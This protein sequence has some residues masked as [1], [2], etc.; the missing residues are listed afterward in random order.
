[1]RN[2]ANVQ[3]EAHMRD[4]S[5]Q[6]IVLVNEMKGRVKF[7]GETKFAKGIWYGIE[8]DKP[9]G[10]NDGSV[11]G[12]RYFDID[13][14][15]ANLNGG[16]YGLFCR[17]DTLRFYKPTGDEHSSPNGN[18]AQETIKKLQVECES[19]T[20]ELNRRKIENHELKIAAENL[21]ISETDLLSKT[22]DLDKL[23]K[24]L[25]MENGNMKIH[26]ENF[27]KM[28]DVPNDAMARDLDK[29]TL[30]ERNCL[31]QG[32]LEQ[33]KL[34]YDKAMKMQEDLLEE[35]TQLLEENA[36]LSKKVSDLGLQLQQTN[37]T[38]G[39]LVL[40]IEAQSKSSNIVDRLTND[41]IL[42]T[43]NIKALNSELEE[44]HV[45]EELE[46]NLRITYEQLEQELRLQLSN[47][48]SALENKKEL[49]DTY[50]EENERLK[51]TLE[52]FEEKATHKS[53]S[54]EL[55]VN[56]LQEELYQNKL[57]K[58]FYQIYEPFTQSHLQ[59]LS[60]QLQYLAEVIESENFGNLENIQIYTILKVLSS[61]SYTLHIHSMEN[62]SDH[63]EETLQCFKV[64][65]A[66]ISMWL[67][68][69]LQRKFSS[70]QETAFSICHFLDENKYLD[71]DV[72]LILK[73]LYPIF[74]TTVPKL[75]AFF[76]AS[77]NLG[78]D[79]TL[80][81][82]GSLY[83]MSFS[84]AARIDKFIVNKQ[85]SIPDNS[86]LLTPSCNINSSSI[87]MTF[88]SGPL[89]FPQ[90]Y[91]RICSLKKLK[92]FFEGVEVL[93]ENIII[94]TEQPKQPSI[95]SASESNN[96]DS[97][98]LNSLV[99]DHLNE[100]NIRLKEVLLQKENVL[101]ELET[102][103]KIFMGRDSE[104][105]TLEQ[106][107]K[108]LQVEL[109]NKIEENCGKSEMLNK[110][111]EENANLLNRLKNMELSLYQIK[112]NSK[113]NKIYLDREKVDRVNLVSEIMELKETIKRRIKEHKQV[114]IDFSWLDE[115]PTME[116]KQSSK[117]HLYRSLN[118]LEIEM[119]NFMS[120][121]RIL[122]MK[123]DR[124]LTEDELWHENDRSY[125][126][127]L[128][129]KRKNIRIK[130]QNTFTYNK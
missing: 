120:T 83:E 52:S 48:Q 109:N 113:L 4:I 84:F 26:L 16:Y 24:K 72:T 112:D 25:K 9:L 12:T 88:F 107:V 115:F 70:K 98:F 118:T 63:L 8:L 79:D 44:L 20:F 56:T 64:N 54:L 92:A 111:K 39:D 96:K 67:S 51:A 61:I 103:I 85:V 34:S 36:V 66:P 91:K 125:I 10:K 101:T 90:E 13:V 3:V 38:I 23:V 116:N 75:L 80:C 89:F 71:K 11:S 117:G 29:D 114:R 124:S 6:D 19:L 97:N 7:I 22:S 121:S 37:N 129:R 104:R 46:E 55:K 110:L 40:Q 95:S 126:A 2:N 30:Q 60:S 108:T 82:I 102:K 74:E 45:K 130:S 33:T 78:D 122:D 28:L 41:N 119:V 68:E 5:L 93:L 59:A 73:I 99:S 1:M 106:S 58:N 50:I 35:N 27:N 87:L 94:S 62:A 128:K 77:S 105:K 69:F 123:L 17:R 43:S 15:K 76:R 100:E 53:Q 21:S 57:L 81:F 14:K 65:I 32:L 127:Y 86:L 42:L 18:T 31:L 49:A 47:L